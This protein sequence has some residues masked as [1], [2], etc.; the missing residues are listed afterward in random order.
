[1][2]TVNV[3]KRSPVT[4]SKF[5]S[6]QFW[7]FKIPCARHASPQNA[8]YFGSESDLGFKIRGKLSK[9]KILKLEKS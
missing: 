3:S 2:E 7:Y 1:M 6:G 8:N 9:K 5:L 4:L